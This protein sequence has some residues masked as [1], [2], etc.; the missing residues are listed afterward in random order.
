MNPAEYQ[1]MYRV[2]DTHW[3]Y[4]GMRRIASV[5]LGDRLTPGDRILDAGCGTGGNL[6]WI[7]GAS[8][9][10]SRRRTGFG[11]D[12]SKDAMGFC[13]ARNLAR[14]ARASVCA[15]PYASESF[16]GVLSFDVIYHLGVASDQVALCE[17]AR[18]LRPGGWALVRVPAFDAL[19]SEHDAAV[20]TRER[21]QLAS[22]KE[23]VSAAGLVIERASY[24]NT[25]LF[26]IAAI[27]RMLRRP[28]HEP[29]EPSS[30][31]RPASGTAQAI[32]T[33]ALRLEALA[34]ARSSLPFGLSAIVLATRPREVL[35]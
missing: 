23:R 14:V 29:G 11:V 17:A 26:P 5:L 30:D 7:E 8:S 25:L 1:A 22:L 32:G 13:Q 15:L 4:E 21:Y 33:L 24:A 6:V 35:R 10:M 31:V 12:L 2:E 27:S 20:H 3:W 28:S 9:Q 19:Q 18:V 34:L 16:D